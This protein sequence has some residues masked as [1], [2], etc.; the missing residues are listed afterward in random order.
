MDN[1]FVRCVINNMLWVDMLQLIK[2]IFVAKIVCIYKE[3]FGNFDV[4]N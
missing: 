1:D 3:N 4:L 2:L